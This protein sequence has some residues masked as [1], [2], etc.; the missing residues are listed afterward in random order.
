MK[1]VAS[2][3]VGMALGV[4]GVAILNRTEMGRTILASDK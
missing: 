3:L 4:A 1:F 2:I